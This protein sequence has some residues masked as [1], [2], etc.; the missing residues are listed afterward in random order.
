[1]WTIG[2]LASYVNEAYRRGHFPPTRALFTRRKILAYYGFLGDGNFGDELVFEAAKRLFEPNILLL[3]KRRMPLHLAAWARIFERRFDGIVIAGGTLLGKSFY[4]R[5]FFLHLIRSGKPIYMHG[6]G[7]GARDTWNSGWCEVMERRVWG[8]VRGPLSVRNAAE[9][10]E[11]LHVVGDAA[12]SLFRSEL[13]SESEVKG[14]TVLINLGAHYP[15]DDLATS[16]SAVERFVAEV[17]MRGFEVKFLPCHWI[18]IGLGR[19]LAKRHPAIE[20]LSI[21]K[22][23][24]EAERHFRS[25]AFAVGE[26]LHFTVMAMLARCPFFSVNYAEKHQDLLASV[27]LWGAGCAPRDVS[28]EGIRATFEA[29]ERFDWANAFERMDQFQ[30]SQRE[31]ARAFLGLAAHSPFFAPLF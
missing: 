14:S 16:R 18:D 17:I 11:K 2:K 6:T 13:V 10:E 31:E 4:E 9:F 30:E 26:R 15:F 28:A 25:S 27:G 5:S 7:I 20:I 12:F 22:S 8:G 23:C 19:E 3:I 29:R 1:M 21:P 24:A